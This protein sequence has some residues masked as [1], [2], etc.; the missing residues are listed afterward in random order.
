MNK[1]YFFKGMKSALPI[2]AGYFAVSFTIGI[3]A[4][5]SGMSIIQAGIMSMLNLSSTGEFAG[6]KI[7]AAS[8]S[9][10]EAA[11]MQL[12]INARYLLMSAVLS[13]KLSPKT[14][15]LKRLITG[16]GV[17]DEIFGISVAEQGEL[18]PY[19]SMGAIAVANPGWTVGTMIGAALG[20][21]LPPLMVSAFSVSLYG[22]FI[23]VFIPPAKNSGI[24]AAAVAVSFA[25]SYAFNTLSLF[26]GISSSTKI[27]ILTVVISVAA[28]ALFPIKQEDE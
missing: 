5:A 15:L 22:M 4:A 1:Y 26:Q 10:I 3:T 18:D 14:S 27:I 11:I 24:I 28:A 6:L 13:Q 12:I 17:T 7:I 16:F 9:L 8:G 19:F 20:G 21:I 23:A 2:A 25:A